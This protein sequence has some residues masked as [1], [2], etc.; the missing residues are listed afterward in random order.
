[1]T[2]PVY[3]ETYQTFQKCTLQAEHV[4][5]TKSSIFCRESRPQLYA[6]PFNC[7]VCCRAWRETALINGNQGGKQK[8][9]VIV[10]YQKKHPL[11]EHSHSTALT[12]ST[13][14]PCFSFAI[15]IYSSTV[16]KQCQNYSLVHLALL[17]DRI[18]HL[19]WERS[20]PPALTHCIAPGP[21]E[22]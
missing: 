22:C 1:M 13:L 20:L 21:P 15:A 10:L 12:C 19:T 11:K 18:S 16:T 3:Q 2:C 14:Y 4:M 5:K 9:C 6:D 17:Y 7:S 8:S